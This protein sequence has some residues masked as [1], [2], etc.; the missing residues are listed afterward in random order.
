MEDN[1]LYVQVLRTDQVVLGVFAEEAA[2][3][4]ADASF[5]RD[6]SKMFP[7]HDVP[8]VHLGRYVVIGGTALPSAPEG[9]KWNPHAPHIVELIRT[10]LLE[11]RG[12]V[13]DLQKMLEDAENGS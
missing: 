1:T 2:A 9:P 7:T 10:R 11:A 6:H 13:E 5:T 3:L 8:K 4:A 12:R